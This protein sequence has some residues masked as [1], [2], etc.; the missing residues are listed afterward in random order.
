MRIAAAEY[1]RARAA[2]HETTL[3][4]LHPVP[5]IVQRLQKP[6]VQN[7]HLLVR[8]RH[9]RRLL[10]DD[11]HD[12][13]QVRHVLCFSH[14][15]AL[16][17]VSDV[18]Q[19]KIQVLYIFSLLLLFVD[20]F[21]I[22]FVCFIL[23]ELALLVV[24]HLKPKLRDVM[25]AERVLRMVSGLIPHFQS[26]LTLGCLD[27]CFLEVFEGNFILEWTHHRVEFARIPDHLRAYEL[28]RG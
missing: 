15:V 4:C 21:G 14:V 24:L 25:L 22:Y 8:K 5:A 23:P 11:F 7:V 28:L 16:A 3:V 10:G 13:P 2:V 18:D 17:L 26:H 20:F 1:Y 12:R 19:R 27:L 6:L 9:S